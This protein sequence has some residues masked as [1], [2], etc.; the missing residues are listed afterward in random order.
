MTLRLH[1]TVYN[2]G[3]P[4]Q[5][6]YLDRLIEQKIAEGVWRVTYTSGRQVINQWGNLWDNE[7]MLI[8]TR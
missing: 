6:R 8:R 3:H 1:E 2:Q 5:Q 7:W 4:L